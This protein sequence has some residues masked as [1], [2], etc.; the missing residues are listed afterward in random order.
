MFRPTVVAIFREVQLNQQTQQH[1]P[2][3]DGVTIYT[4]YLQTTQLKQCYKYIIFSTFI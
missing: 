3:L 2:R 4:A 1:S